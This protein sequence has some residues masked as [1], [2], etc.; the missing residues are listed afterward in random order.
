M[1][2]RDEVG[3]DERRVQT[4]RKKTRGRANERIKRESP[5]SMNPSMEVK[6]A[7]GLG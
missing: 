4:L 7:R 3:R 6:K 5:S 2:I 1:N